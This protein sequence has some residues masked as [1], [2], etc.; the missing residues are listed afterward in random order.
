M[1]ITVDKHQLFK[2]FI[3][4]KTSTVS[5]LNIRPPLL[6]SCVLAISKLL[7]SLSNCDL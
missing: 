3:S 5:G 7:T 6:K 4:Q 1:F 2:S